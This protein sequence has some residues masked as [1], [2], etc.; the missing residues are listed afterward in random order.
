MSSVKVIAGSSSVII[1]ALSVII[2][3]LFVI[4]R[5]NYFLSDDAQHHD[6]MMQYEMQSDA[7]ARKMG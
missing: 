6:D 5:F 2:L 1:S 7:D 4:I 3:D